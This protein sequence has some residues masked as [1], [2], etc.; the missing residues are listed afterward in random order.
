MPSRTTGSKDNGDRMTLGRVLGSRIAAL[1]GQ[2]WEYYASGDGLAA[3]AWTT[4]TEG[5]DNPGKLDMTGAVDLSE[6]RRYLLIGW[7]YPAG[8]GKA[9]DGCTQREWS[10][11]GA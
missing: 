4:K 2:D 7:Y 10:F 6:R 8:G 11:Y 9:K 5:V 1:R 3:S